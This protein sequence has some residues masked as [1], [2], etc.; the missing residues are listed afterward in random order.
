[1]DPLLSYYILGVIKLL[2]HLGMSLA[3]N[4]ILLLRLSATYFHALCACTRVVMLPYG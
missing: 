2:L 1:M 4:N 3:T